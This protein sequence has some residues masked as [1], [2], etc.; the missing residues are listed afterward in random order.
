MLNQKKYSEINTPNKFI[1]PEPTP[2]PPDKLNVRWI[3]YSK[4][5]AQFKKVQEV[6]GAKTPTE[7]GDSTF[8]Y[9]LQMECDE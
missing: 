4:P 9:F 2:L 3:R 7:V 5:V 6:I 8:D 1:A